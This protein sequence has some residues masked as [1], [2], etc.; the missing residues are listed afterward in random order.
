[1]HMYSYVFSGVDGV[2]FAHLVGVEPQALSVLRSVHMERDREL[3]SERERD[4]TDDAACRESPSRAP[5]VGTLGSSSGASCS[6]TSVAAAASS[7]SSGSSSSSSSSNIGSSPSTT[8]AGLPSAAYHCLTSQS[9]LL[10]LQGGSLPGKLLWGS[11]NKLPVIDLFRILLLLGV[12][13]EPCA[14][15]LNLYAYSYSS[16]A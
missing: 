14:S 2:P 3:E 16:R 6:R 10:S 8:I 5:L 12:L 9:S 1:M 13:Q 11:E 7:A 4:A 15:S